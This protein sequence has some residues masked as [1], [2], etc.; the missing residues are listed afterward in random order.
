MNNLKLK[1]LSGSNAK[2]RLYKYQDF[3]EM[4]KEFNKIKEEQE[5]TLFEK[6]ISL[7][8][9]LVAA[10]CFIFGTPLFLS[11]VLGAF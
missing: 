5:L 7:F 2:D 11:V 1:S 9:G 8:I 10:I 3:A 4:S 6:S